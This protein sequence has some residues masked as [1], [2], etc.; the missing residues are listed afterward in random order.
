MNIFTT[1]D[2]RVKNNKRIP[3]SDFLFQL[4]FSEHNIIDKINIV[5]DAQTSLN[6]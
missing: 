4:Q 6:L 3:E 1:K 2:R 5:T